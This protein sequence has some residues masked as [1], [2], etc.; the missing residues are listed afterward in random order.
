MARPASPL[1]YPGGKAFLAGVL[2]DVIALNGLSDGVYVEPYCG[3]AGAAL[4]LLFGEYVQRILLNDA[5]PA[6]HAFW[7]SAMRRTDAFMAL[8][9]E[10]PITIEEW[11]RQRGIYRVKPRAS[12][13]ELGFAALYLNRCN[14][15]GIIVDGGPIGGIAQKGKWK[16]DA[17]FNRRELI[18][19][20]ERLSAYRD[21]VATYN[22][23]AI[24]F[25]RDVVLPHEQLRKTLVYLDPPYYHKGSDLY[26]NYYTPEDHETL[27]VFL[28]TEAPFKWVLSYD[29]VPEIRHLYCGLRQLNTTVPYCAHSRRPGHELLICSHDTELPHG[30]RDVRV[31]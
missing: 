1:R 8:L 22:M 30:W 19:R 14:R 7:T 4:T 13:T 17:R 3:G 20:L 21:R 29:D 26:A 15:S 18:R 31:N 16:L 12:R 28:Q 11:R 10:T 6:V 23:D 9:K 27:A 2:A 24:A 5:D 25:L